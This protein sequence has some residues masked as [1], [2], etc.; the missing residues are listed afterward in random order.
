MMVDGKYA[1]E[2]KTST[3]WDESWVSPYYF[4]SGT[5]PAPANYADKN[6]AR[7]AVSA[8]SK[9]G[10]RG[11]CPMGWHVPTDYEWA[12]LLD[13]VEGDGT[14]STFISQTG[15]DWWGADAGTKL[16]S[17]GTFT[18]T[19]SDPGDGKWLE[20]ANCGTDDFG[21]SLL[22]SGYR[23]NTGTYFASRGGSTAIWSSVVLGQG[24]AWDRQFFREYAQVQRRTNSCSFAFSVRC[25][26]D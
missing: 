16:K 13:K 7:G 20:S 21:F 8:N 9:G 12:Y 11:I 2:E 25:V 15:I 4:A 10:G 3:A 18:A 14:S 19:S 24:G 6:N 17:S 26:R 23:T 22:P 1:D 5:A